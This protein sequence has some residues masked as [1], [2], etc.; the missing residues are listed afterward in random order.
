MEQDCLLGASFSLLVCFDK[1]SWGIVT[2]S[3]WRKSPYSL[4][5]SEYGGARKRL[6]IG[7]LLLSG[8]VLSFL[9]L[10]FWGIPALGFG[11]IHPLLPMLTGVLSFVLLLFFI[12]LCYSRVRHISTGASFWGSRELRNATIRTLYPL[13]ELWG[14]LLR[15]ERSHIRLSFIKVNNELVLASRLRVVPEK[16]LLLL[17]HCIQRSSCTHRLTPEG[18][19]CA[20]CGACPIDSLLNLSERYGFHL[21]IATGGTIA[22]RIVV[23]RR[24]ELILAVAC[25]RDLA[26]GIQDSYPIPVFGILNERP[27]GPCVDTLVASE[28]VER[29]VCTFLDS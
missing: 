19:H 9:L 8:G 15:I 20:R 29:M 2:M 26:S 17:P 27:C 25:E 5:A 7:L 3:F 11:N 13:M 24:P 14:S 21:A 28:R 23:Q 22:R 18:K 1:E 16:L 10:C 6:F 12:C 4:P